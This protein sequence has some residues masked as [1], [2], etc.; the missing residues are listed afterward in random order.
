MVQ[1]SRYTPSY[2]LPAGLN[3]F[4]NPK[5]LHHLGY[6]F[7]LHLVFKISSVTSS[8]SRLLFFPTSPHPGVLLVLSLH[9]IASVYLRNTN[10]FTPVSTGCVSRRGYFKFQRRVV[11]REGRKDEGRYGFFTK[12]TAMYG[13]YSSH[14]ALIQSTAIIS[15]CQNRSFV[16]SPPSFEL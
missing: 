7:Y 2:S 15:V 3:A 12:E 11:H 10:T 8:D 4:I 9:V 13:S 1:V 6:F 14:H 16:P 5:S